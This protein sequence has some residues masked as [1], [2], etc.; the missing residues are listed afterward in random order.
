MCLQWCAVEQTIQYTTPLKL[1]WRPQDTAS[2]LT[3]VL[4]CLSCSKGWPLYKLSL[5]VHFCCLLFRVAFL[6]SCLTTREAALC[7]ILVLS[8]CMYVFMYICVDDTFE[9]LDVGSSY[10]HMLH[11]FTVYGS[12]S[13]RAGMFVCSM[14]FWVWQIERCNRHL[15]NM[16][17]SEHA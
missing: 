5:S 3:M 4:S 10:L 7:I 14:G 15:C 6:D 13:Y 11:M 8:V 12:S 9:S 16:T 17:R 2:W 1:S